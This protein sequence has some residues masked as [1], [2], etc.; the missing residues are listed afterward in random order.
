MEATTS[1]TLMFWLAAL[2]CM[3]ASA[4]M[5]VPSGSMEETE[6][7]GGCMSSVSSVHGCVEAIHEVVWHLKFDGLKHECCKAINL[8]G[9]HCLPV[10]FPDIPMVSL[11]INGVCNLFG[12]AEKVAAAPSPYY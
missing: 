8:V 3:A 9:D 11:L 1:K 2:T 6:N 5:V 7:L 12:D 10:L 4:A